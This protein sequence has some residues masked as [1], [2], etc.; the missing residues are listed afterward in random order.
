MLSIRGL[1][2]ANG[3]SVAFGP[4]DLDVERGACVAVMGASGSGKSLLL[5][6]IAE[7]DISS[8]SVALN[9]V[10]REMISAPRWR[11]QVSYLA[12]ETGWWAEA[13]AAH[14][15]DWASARAT[16]RRLGFAEDCGPWPIQRLSTGERQR[17]G[18]ARILEHGPAVLLLDEPTG[19]LDTVTQATVETL[20]Y[21]HLQAGGCSVVVTHDV[22]Q[23]H[24]IA[25]RG[26]ELSDGR[27]REVWTS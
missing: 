12:A 16:V 5:R 13:V 14:F 15:A 11:S 7:L 17:L 24:R 9:G 22:D 27:L 10:E 3:G 25:R 26:Y 20:L 23:M 4:A 19:G 18:F 2:H 21:E 6:A 1:R 8:G